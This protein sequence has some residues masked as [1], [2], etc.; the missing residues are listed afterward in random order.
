MPSF[1]DLCNEA[2]DLVGASTITSLSEDSAEA[3]LCLRLYPQLLERLLCAYPW[4]CATTRM[5]LEEAQPHEGKYYLYPLPD[6]CLRVLA[7][8]ALEWHCETHKIETVWQKILLCDQPPGV[9]LRYIRR[10][11][12]PM[13]LDP[14]LAELF[15]YE[16]AARL[17]A[18]LIE[19][20]S[21]IETF[22]A[23]A[24]LCRKRAMHIDGLERS[25]YYGEPTWFEKRGG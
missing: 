10:I 18:K 14:L 21:R 1:L 16:L 20:A 5:T 15:I 24:E 13:Q 25:A 9:G 4:N 7:C 8:D 19:S 11:E 6:D 2:L 22:L 23:R 3:K 12:D 17:A